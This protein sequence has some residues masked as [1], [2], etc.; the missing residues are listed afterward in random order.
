MNFNWENI[1]Q[2]GYNTIKDY[3][4]FKNWDWGNTSPGMRELLIKEFSGKSQYE[5]VYNVKE[6]DIVVD[7]GASSGVFTNSIIDKKPNSIYCLEPSKN[8]FECLMKNLSNNKNIT[9]I[10]KGI[11]H[12]SGYNSSYSTLDNMKL[13]GG[14][15]DMDGVKFSKFLSNHKIGF[16]DF[17]KLDCE[18]GEYQIFTDE[19]I[20]Y[21]LNNVGCIVGEWHLGEIDQKIDFRHFRDK[22]LKLFKNV[23][24]FS[25]DGVNIKWDLYNDHFIEYYQNV[26]FHISNN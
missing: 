16:I 19:N 20:E 10:N 17:L 21:L 23:E 6:N 2:I 11:S 18:G 12:T 3:M 14:E 9:F 13:Y 22:Y 1:A 15:K 8:M 4:K 5:D 7:I 25:V 26:I 24:V